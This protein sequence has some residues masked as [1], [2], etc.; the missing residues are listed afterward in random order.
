MDL[1]IISSHPID[2][3]YLVLRLKALGYNCK[4]SSDYIY[5]MIQRYADILFSVDRSL[6]V[7]P[8]DG[9]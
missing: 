9:K 5:Y 8:N 7:L 6:L 2:L 4:Q 1:R 3:G